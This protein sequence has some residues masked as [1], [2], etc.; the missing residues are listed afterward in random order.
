[1]YMK[2]FS[3]F[4]KKFKAYAENNDKI[5]CAL[6]VGSYAR[7][8]CRED[9]DLDI[10]IITPFKSEFTESDGF[11][12]AFGRVVRSQTEYYGACTSL[13]VWYSSGE[14]IEFGFVNPQWIK[15]PLDPGTLGVLHDGYIV[16]T[17]KKN[18][19]KAL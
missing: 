11:A 2:K 13:R 4:L 8:A 7:G 9:S 19:F 10:V 5:D 15:M 17:D 3:V 12:N 16:L 1:M 6:I 14:E 18:Y